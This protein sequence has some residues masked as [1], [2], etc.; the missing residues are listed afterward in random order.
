MKAKDLR[1]R[2]TEDLVEL[3]KTLRK[4]LFAHR[5]KNHTSQLSDTSLLNKT[6]KDI[7][8]IELILHERLSVD[9]AEAGPSAQADGGNAQ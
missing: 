9:G 6:R 1:E 2:T 3:R 5:M 8:R 7:S 4:D